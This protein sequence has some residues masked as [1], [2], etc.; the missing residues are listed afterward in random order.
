MSAE[1]KVSSW[2][3]GEDF[4]PECMGSSSLKNLDLGSTAVAG[5]GDSFL[6]GQ[7]LWQGWLD[8]NL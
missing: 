1:A 4:H 2:E 3:Q 5:S 8:D 6:Q 7:E